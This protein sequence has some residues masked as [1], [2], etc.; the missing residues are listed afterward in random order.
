MII[1]K[2]KRKQNI[3]EYILYMYQIEDTIRA[4]DFKME[5]I[6][7]RIIAQFTVGEK[8][9]QEIRDWYSDIMV[10]MYQEGVRESGHISLL[11]S[12]VAELSML[13]HKIINE[14]QDPKYLKKYSFAL[15]N[16][17]VFEKKIGKD[18]E[19]EIDTC[20][21]ALYALL[22]LR[23]QK[24]EISRETIEAMQTFSNMLALLADWFRKVEEGKVEL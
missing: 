8:V 12:L 15:P 7:Q 11:S 18:P 19:S 24:K 20:V 6:E 21:T 22:L 9:Q 5:L 13:H 3:V 10:M 17:R 2:E 14:K 1:A 16:I 23:L 4:C